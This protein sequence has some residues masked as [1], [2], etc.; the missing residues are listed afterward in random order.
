MSKA[1][2]PP[3]TEIDTGTKLRIACRCSFLCSSQFTTIILRH[4]NVSASHRVQHSISTV[5]RFI[6]TVCGVHGVDSV[7]ES[8]CSA[9]HGVGVHVHQLHAW[10]QII[11]RLGTYT[12]FRYTISSSNFNAGISYSI[13]IICRYIIPTFHYFQTEP[14]QR[15][16]FYF[17]KNWSTL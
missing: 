9:K 3:N 11:S 17:Y 14:F 1:R 10:H 2:R 4:R 13:N 15:A 5:F 6:A 8:K 7:N 12:T 16:R